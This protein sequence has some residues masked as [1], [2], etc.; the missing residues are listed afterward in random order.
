MSRFRRALAPAVVLAWA[1]SGPRAS[2][3]TEAPPAAPAPTR[4]PAVRSPGNA[5]WEPS[6]ARA[7]VRAAREGKFVFVE[8]DEEGCGNCQRMDA[9]LYPA[10][11][12][13]ALLLEM[14]PV[15]TSRSSPEGASTAARYGIGEVPALL[16]VT[17]EG[18][19]VFLMQG[20]TSAPQFYQHV[21]QDL[22]AYRAFARRVELQNV[23]KLPAKEAFETG[24]ELSQ[25]RDAAAAVPRLERVATAP[26]AT[27][28]MRESA[29]QLAAE[30]QLD[31]AKPDAARRTIEKLIATTKDAGRRERAE[32]L[33]AQI[34]L[35]EKKPAE[36]LA[37][38]RAFRQKYPQSKYGG[39]VDQLIRR[40]EQQGA[41]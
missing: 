9:L 16:V 40:L 21:K 31:L 26:G 34:P 10:F 28:E 8:L 39:D 41:R 7:R 30:A 24:R 18:R 22:D 29:L 6:I 5:E 17:P 32:L 36:A 2:G 37:L 23:A 3:Q 15:K 14:V 35:T 25:R 33:R 4:T 27:R 12:F 1:V 11:D 38:F 20:F 19:L 13:E